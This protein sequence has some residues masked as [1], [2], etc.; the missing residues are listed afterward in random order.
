[1]IGIEYA[2]VA[3]ALKAQNKVLKADEPDK[4]LIDPTTSR[5]V[6][7]YP[8]APFADE[9]DAERRAERRLEDAAG[10]FCD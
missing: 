10:G 1:M 2:T 4:V 5:I 9:R 6:I 8:T 7:D 3:D